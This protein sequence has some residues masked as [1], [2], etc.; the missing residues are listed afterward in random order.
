MYVCMFH[1][2]F[3]GGGRKSCIFSSQIQSYTE[4]IFHLVIQEAKQTTNRVK[5]K[6]KMQQKKTVIFERSDLNS[7]DKRHHFVCNVMTFFFSKVY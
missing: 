7:T 6:S 2:F 3:V 1:L 5:E 4:Q